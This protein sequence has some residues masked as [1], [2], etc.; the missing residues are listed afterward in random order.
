MRAPRGVDPTQCLYC[1]T[2][3]KMSLYPESKESFHSHINTQTV[4]KVLDRLIGR[5]A[6]LR[7]IVHLKG[8]SFQRRLYLCSFGA[9]SVSLLPCPDM[10]AVRRLEA[11]PCDGY[12]S[13][14]SRAR[15]CDRVRFDVFFA[16]LSLHIAQVFSSFPRLEKI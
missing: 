5:R 15:I 2:D 6:C 14:C 12:R 7:L 4:F 3:T 13:A 8:D 1:C 9:T 11:V 16:F 10:D